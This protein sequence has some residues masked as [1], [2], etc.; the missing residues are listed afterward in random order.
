MTTYTHTA[1]TPRFGHLR[2]HLRAYLVGVG[3]TT[4]LIAG[5]MVV[6][7]SLATFV[8]F[9][10]LPFAGLSDDAGAAFLGS[11]AGAATAPASAAAALGAAHAAVANDPVPGSHAS[12]SGSGGGSGAGNRSGGANDPAGGA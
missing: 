5:A 9:K 3:A 6:F 2:A 8:A 10:G 11:N 7:L 12:G 4:A 1:S